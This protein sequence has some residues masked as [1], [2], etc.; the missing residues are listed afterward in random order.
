MSLLKTKKMTID[1]QFDA[2]RFARLVKENRERLG[3]TQQELADLVGVHK[4]RIN[5][6]E[7]CGFRKGPSPKRGPT[8]NVLLRLAFI[9]Q[10]SVDEL[11]GR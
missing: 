7:H 8:A 10:V 6:Y 5:E 9:F 1:I 4:T 3:L 11:I 2:Q